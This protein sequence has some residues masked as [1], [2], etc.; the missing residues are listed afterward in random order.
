M[1][2]RCPNCG[3]VH[4]IDSLL[5]AAGAA[6]LIKELADLGALAAPALRYLGLFRPAAR[7]LSFARAARL[8]AAV[9]PDIRAGQIRR[10]GQIYPAPSEAWI[11]GFQTA[12]DARDSGRLKLPLKSHGYLYEIISQ[13]RPQTVQTAHTAMPVPAIPSRTLAAA[14][15]LEGLKR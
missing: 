12:L 2:T 4:S 7:Q 11:H 6:A 14:A 9:A 15:Q 8:L 13:W 3:A 10:D 1:N 5:A